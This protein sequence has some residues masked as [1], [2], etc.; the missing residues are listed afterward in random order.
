M[1]KGNQGEGGSPLK[2]LKQQFAYRETY[3]LL[4]QVLMEKC[5]YDLS[6]VVGF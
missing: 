5:P 1:Y 2:P 4:S 3:T 6:L